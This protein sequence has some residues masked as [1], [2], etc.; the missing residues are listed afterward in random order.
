MVVGLVVVGWFPSVPAVSHEVG[1]PMAG[2]T[3]GEAEGLAKVLW[4]AATAIFGHVGEPLLLAL[5]V[6]TGWVGARPWGVGLLVALVLVGY[7][8]SRNR[9]GSS[10][11]SGGTSS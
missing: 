7:L 8:V 2:V 11:Q 1:I 6:L 4:K 9:C 3:A 5:G 10:P